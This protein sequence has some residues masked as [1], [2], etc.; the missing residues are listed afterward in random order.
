MA[1]STTAIYQKIVAKT[2]GNETKM[3]DFNQFRR[4]NTSKIYF[5]KVMLFKDNDYSGADL[6][7]VKSE[8]KIII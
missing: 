3:W 1:N 5:T 7:N 8:N 2:L 4:A 6:Q